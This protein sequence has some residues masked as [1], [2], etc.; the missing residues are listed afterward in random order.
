MLMRFRSRKQ[1]RS[2]HETLQ[3]LATAIVQNA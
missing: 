2:A 3:T 1:P